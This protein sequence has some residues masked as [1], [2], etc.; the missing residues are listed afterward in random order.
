MSFELKHSREIT[1]PT[2]YFLVKPHQQNEYSVIKHL[3][4]KHFLPQT[5]PTKPVQYVE[6]VFRLTEQKQDTA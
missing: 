3:L 5:L 2:S 6:S 4:L 1:K